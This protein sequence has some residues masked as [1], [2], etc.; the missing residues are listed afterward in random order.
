MYDSLEVK[1]SDLDEYYFQ[2]PSFSK[3]H[4]IYK[5]KTVEFVGFE[6]NVLY[7]SFWTEEE[8]LRPATGKYEFCL[9]KMKVGLNRE[10]R[11]ISMS[12]IE[13]LGKTISDTNVNPKKHV[14][15]SSSSKLPPPPP[16]QPGDSSSE[17]AAF[18]SEEPIYIGGLENLYTDLYSSIE[19]PEVEREK[20]IS[21]TV[22]VAFVVEWDGSITNVVVEK[23]V[24]NGPGLDKAAAAAVSKLGFFRPAQMN[25]KS[26]RYRYRVP[27]KFS[28][29]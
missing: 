28:L 13:S 19:Y 26:V 6:S 3:L 4:F 23:G 9:V 12:E 27:I 16:S 24:A 10:G 22:Y 18:V 5:K 15:V 8:L 20:N 7:F 25:G 17:I 2:N 29:Q 14:S 1:S 21:G 11:I